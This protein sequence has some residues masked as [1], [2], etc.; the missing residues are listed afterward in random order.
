[1]SEQNTQAN[2]YY[3]RM[4]THHAQE[5]TSTDWKHAAYNY[6]LQGLRNDCFRCMSRAEELH[7]QESYDE[8][9][10][11][12]TFAEEVYSDIRLLRSIGAHQEE[13]TYLYDAY[14]KTKR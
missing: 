9:G 8:E 6:W 11:T 10:Y 4:I 2:K 5:L 3:E 12:P 7:T 1:M 13:L 14:H